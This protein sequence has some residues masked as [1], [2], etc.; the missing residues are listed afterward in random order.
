MARKPPAPILERRCKPREVYHWKGNLLEIN[1]HLDIE[2]IFRF[3]G[4][5][6]C[7][8]MTC[9]SKLMGG[10]VGVGAPNHL[11][12]SYSVKLCETIIFLGFVLKSCYYQNKN[13][14]S[15]LEGPSSTVLHVNSFDFFVKVIFLA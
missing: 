4:F 9:R 15:R 3:Y 11:H 2:N 7:W 14:G 12:L 1:V 5:V 8:G 13:Q 6:V 10:G